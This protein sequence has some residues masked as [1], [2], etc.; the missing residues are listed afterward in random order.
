MKW[1]NIKDQLPDDDREVLAYSKE[2]GITVGAYYDDRSLDGGGE[3]IPSY[4]DDADEPRINGQV[5]HWM[6][7]PKYPE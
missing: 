1:I 7:L 2:Y 6:E 4:C 5:T 3:W